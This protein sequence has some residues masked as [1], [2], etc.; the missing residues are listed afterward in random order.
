MEAP[1]LIH[2][3]FHHWNLLRAEREPWLAI[4][5]K[6]VAAEPAFEIGPLLYNPVPTI[7]TRP[8]LAKLTER[9]LDLLA[10]R[11]GLDR[12]RLLACATVAAALSA[13]WSLES[14]D[15]PTGMIGFIGILAELD[16]GESD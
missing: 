12:K 5:P 15:V 4:D 9:R 7:F 8:D 14:G 2:G 11:L 16:G 3:D 6:G 1:V 13:C 10:E